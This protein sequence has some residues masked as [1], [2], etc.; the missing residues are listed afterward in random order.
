MMQPTRLQLDVRGMPLVAHRW[1][2]A[3]APTILAFH[4]FLDHG[5]SFAAIAERLV[6]RW[7][8]VAP[9]A[10][11]HG[12][13][14][15][16]GDGGQYYFYDYYHDAARWL[17]HLGLEQVAVIGHSMGGMIA[18]GLAALAPD[19]VSSVVLLDGMGP[20]ERRAEGARDQLLRWV[21]ACDRPEFLASTAGRR[22]QR[23]AMP[24]LQAAADR[25]IAANA[26][27]PAGMAAR[28]AAT[29][30]EPTGAGFTWRHDPLHRTPSVRP[31]RADEARSL[32]RA[33]TMPVLSIYAE[34][35][36]WR[37][38]DLAERHACLPQGTAA[39]LAAAGHNLHHEQPE[40]LADAIALW[41]SQ[42]QLAPGLE[43]I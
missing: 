27:L 32:W 26:R 43:R 29:G 11:G 1:G 33:M 23:R 40:L 37:P 17:Q 12:W 15:W 25:L 24:S 28:L 2:P 20:P 7:S 34:H 21:E 31:F 16:V 42:R 4:G 10:R 19:K 5:E 22:A 18:T 8:L 39:Q 3:D 6:P 36:E 35:S 14:G 38:D 41:L 30:T 13:S 9:D